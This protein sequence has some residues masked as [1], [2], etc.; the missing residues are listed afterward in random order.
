M[1]RLCNVGAAELLIPHE[2]FRER[3]IGQQLSLELAN[4]LRQE[5]ACSME[6]MLYRLVDFAEEPCAVVFL[7]KR[8]K[9]QGNGCPSD[10]IWVGEAGT[11]IRIDYMRAWRAL[12]DISAEQRFRCVI[13]YTVRP[14]SLVSA[15]EIGICGARSG[16]GRS[17]RAPRDCR[18]ATRKSGSVGDVT[19]T[20]EVIL[21]TRCLK[22]SQLRN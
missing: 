17:E 14:D 10:W 18:Q 19:G 9:P 11:E 8:I 2:D 20:L 12:E 16:K 3:V 4:T 22:N 7:S 5:F 6:A 21:L 13:V 1:E 15:V